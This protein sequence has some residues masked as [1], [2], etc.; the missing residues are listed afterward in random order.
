M[1]RQGSL[2]SRSSSASDDQ[3]I[4]SARAIKVFGDLVTDENSLSYSPSPMKSKKLG[5]GLR[6]ITNTSSPLKTRILPFGDIQFTTA[7]KNLK[8]SSRYSKSDLASTEMKEDT[9]DGK[10]KKV[11]FKKTDSS[12]SFSK[13]QSRPT[14]ASSSSSSASTISSKSATTGTTSTSESAFIASKPAYSKKRAIAK[15]AKMSPIKRHVAKSNKYRSNASS[16]TRNT[17][18]VKAQNAVNEATDSV[19]QTLNATRVAKIEHHRNVADEI[20]R[21]REEWLAEKEEAARFNQEVENTRREM[22]D[23]RSQISTQYAQNKVQHDQSKLQERLNELD[24]EIKFKSDVFVEH[25][26]KLKENEDRRRRMSSGLKKEMW[27][28]R[29]TVSKRIEMER[30]EERHHRLEHKWAGERD[31]QEYLKQCAQERRESFAFRNAEGRRQ[32]DE[33][34]E[35]LSQKQFEDH[36]RIEHKWAG[37]EDAKKYLEKCAEE[38]RNSFAFRNAEGRRQRRDAEEER[39][40]DQVAEHEAFE[41]KCAGEKDA[42]E[43]LKKCEQE[44]RNSLAFRNAEGGRQRQEEEERKAQQMM[45]EHERYEHKWGGENDAQEYLEKCD[46]E[47]RESFA[48]RNADG[49]RQRTEEEERAADDKVAEHKR[50]EHKWAGERDADDYRKRCEKARRE[51]LAFRG[52]EVVRHRAVMY[53]LRNIAKEKE[54]ES[55]VLA[56]AAQDDVK[57]YLGKMAEERRQSFAF[58]CQEGKRHR[59]LQEMWKS[60]E[61]E[62]EHE[63]EIARSESKYHLV[64]SYSFASIIRFFNTCFVSYTVFA[65]QKDVEEYKKRC[66]DRDRASL[67]YR[68]KEVQIRR[69]ITEQQ[70]ASEYEED[71]KKRALETLARGDVDEYVKDCKKRRRLSL[72]HRAKESRHHEQWRRTQAQESRETKARHTRNMGIDRRY[73]QLAKE[74]ERARIALDALRHAQCTFSTSNPFGSLLE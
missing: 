30:I 61:I 14:S 21:L 28:E 47:R 74:K 26:Q 44:R 42:E 20:S 62:R 72:A 16:I 63:L 54:H 60:E 49:R 67:V 59:D 41:W 10:K 35:R 23:I 70:Q 27:N 56:W 73:V 39:A 32:R 57:E 34:A 33:E 3:S 7:K 65:G 6:N 4:R 43:Y 55:H 13:K 53:E 52:H 48:F 29:R 25:K 50:Y 68:G 19:N 11:S 17:H 71:Q 66:A 69:M 31:A 8:K 2:G 18:A 22:L 45:A 9:S 38:R 12:A 15:N 46:Q 1:E 64:Q 58:R 51:S 36:R 37:E 5:L 40:L 24:K